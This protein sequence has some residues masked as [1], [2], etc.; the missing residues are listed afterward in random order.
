MVLFFSILVFTSLTLSDVYAADTFTKWFYLGDTFSLDGVNYSIMVS[1]NEQGAM[2]SSLYNDV[3]VEIDQCT[4]KDNYEFCL[5]NITISD[6]TIMAD[7]KMKVKVKLKVTK[8]NLPS[9]TL[10]NLTKLQMPAGAKCLDDNECMSGNCLHQSCTYKKI[11]C[12]DGYCDDQE[13]CASDCV[14]KVIPVNRTYYIQPNMDWIESD[15]ILNK[16]FEHNF[17]VFYNYTLENG[18]KRFKRSSRLALVNSSPCPEVHPGHVVAN[19]CNHCYMLNSTFSITPEQDCTIQFRIN[20]QRLI[21]NTGSARVIINVTNTTKIEVAEPEPE[22]KVA[23]KK[24][25]LEKIVR[26]TPQPAKTDT[27]WIIIGTFIIILV[28]GVV[29]VIAIRRR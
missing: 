14:R 11:I 24:Q 3:I 13:T 28:V 7:P 6:L 2:I 4:N 16:G 23:E 9:F 10:D 26:E 25:V 18:S 12:G 19:I 21:D 27:L 8:N 17:S 5:L 20:E 22:I 15:F 29:I 1:A